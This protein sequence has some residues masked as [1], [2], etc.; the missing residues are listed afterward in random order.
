[1]HLVPQVNKIERLESEMLKLP[2]V[3]CPVRHIFGPGVYIREVTL[4]ADTYA[5]GHHQNFAHLNVMIK[6]RV[7]MHREDGSTFELVAPQTFVGQPGRKAGYVIED[8]I[9]QNIYATTETDVEKLE[10]HYLTMSPVSVEYQKQRFLA[11]EAKHQADRD[12]YVQVLKQLGVSHTQVREQTENTADIVEMPMGNYKFQVAPSPIEGKGV[13]AVH[14]IDAGEVIG[15]ARLGRN[16]TVLGRMV[17]HSVSPNA[18]MI[19]D[20]ENIN[21]VATKAIKGKSGTDMGDE[22]VIDY[23]QAHAQSKRLEKS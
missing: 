11:H 17:N 12:D 19:I 16:R 21:L 13:F 18:E 9:W 6:G 23:R 10:A 14:G 1:M 4:P 15:I 3:D 5:I 20:G 8:T 2:Q 22:I 7:R